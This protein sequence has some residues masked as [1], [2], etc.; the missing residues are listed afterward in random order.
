MSTGINLGDPYRPRRSRLVAR[1]LLVLGVLV[2]VLAAA[3]T[4]FYAGA[5]RTAPPPDVATVNVLVATRDIEARSALGANDVKLVQLPRDAAPPNALHDANAAAGMITTV[6]L[7]ANEPVLPAKI[8]QPGSEGHIA[9]LPPGSTLGSS[10]PAYRAMSLNVPDANAAGGA[11]VAGDHVDIL[12]TLAVSEP[13]RTDFVG[14]I[15]IQDVP[16][17]AKTVT[18]Y[19]FRV[20]ATTAERLAALQA[21]NGNLQLLLRAP[22]D[23][24]PAGTAGASF[25]TEAQRILRP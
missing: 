12:Y 24:R 9:V 6:P 14:R 5:A 16:V 25:T 20:D 4:Y 22:G 1:A 7:A 2:A 19:T 18:V 11:I 23:A 13:T 15:V 17:L 3:G 10:S 8:A 21:S